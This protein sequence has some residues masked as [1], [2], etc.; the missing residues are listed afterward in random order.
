[1]TD[2]A[3]KKRRRRRWFAIT[4]CCLGIAFALVFGELGL[5]AYVGMR[6]WTSNCYAT[7]ALFFVPDAVTGRT[8]RPN[9]HLKSS[10][11]DINVNSL[12]FRGPEV[13]VS[14]PDGVRRIAVM[15]GSSVFGYLVPG[16]Q[17][18]SRK[19]QDI[20]QESDC[21]GAIEVINGG[22]PGFTLAQVLGRYQTQVAQLE[23]DIVILYL[24]W[25]DLPLLI[26]PPTDEPLPQAPSWLERTLAHS[27]LYGLIRYRL[28]PAANPQFAPPP[29]ASTEIVDQSA[30]KFRDTMA[31]L[32]QAIRESGAV[33]VI[34]TQVSAAGREC[35][36]LNRFLG[37]TPEQVTNNAELGRWLADEIRH[38][39]RQHEVTLIDT[40]AKVPCDE[41]ILGD[42]IHLTAHGHQLV[43]EA[44]AEELLPILCPDAAASAATSDD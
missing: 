39:A 38:L 31:E 8:L 42:A 20:L 16:D 23:P 34:A 27:T 1:M 12:G 7:G 30:D 3:E 9:L 25:N 24:G 29:S 37:D 43:A 6:G 5:R 41:T 14:K 28:F 11:Y 15:G 21:D 44:W 33:P 19:L 2:K 40:A 36:N 35:E 18:A 26:R 13:N 22:V 17:A 10:S 4:A 32:I